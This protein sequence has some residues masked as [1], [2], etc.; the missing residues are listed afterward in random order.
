[1]NLGYP[2]DLLTATH[3]NRA[4]EYYN[5][6]FASLLS[7][8]VHAMPRPK[9]SA[10]GETSKAEHIRQT[11]K[12]MGKKVRPKEIIAALKEQGVVVTSPQVS[13]TLKAAGYRRK[14]R[15]SKAASGAT[16][17]AASANGLTLNALV[18]AKEF[19][20]KAGGIKAAEAAIHAM[21]KL[22]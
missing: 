15:G 4:A 18:A 21:K 11:A 8:G 22:G 6:L 5:R 16:T 12:Q 13:S 17:T 1:L 20:H 2:S 9:K 10:T 14:R 3:D 7:Y 19:I